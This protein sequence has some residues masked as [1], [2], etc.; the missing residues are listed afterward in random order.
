[1]FIG[2]GVA[3]YKVTGDRNY[4]DDAITTADFV[5]N[6]NNLAPAGILKTERSGDGGL[7]K[8]ILVRYMVQIIKS[9]GLPEGK[10]AAYSD[11]LRQNAVTLYNNIRRPEMLIG[12]S[13]DK[14]SDKIIDASVQLSGLM[15]LEAMATL[16]KNH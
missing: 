8:G 14:R 6:D 12:P 9:P 10:K 13:W 7:F 5:I 15:L 1:M 2:A 11:F 3:L 16:D 4:L